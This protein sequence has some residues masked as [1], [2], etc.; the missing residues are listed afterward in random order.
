MAV[1]IGTLVLKGR[2][3]PAEPESTQAQPDLS[4]ALEA[5][6]QEVLRDVDQKL[7]QAA[8]RARER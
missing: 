1:E 6:R 3:G 7:E 5:L 4:D 8:R 2:F